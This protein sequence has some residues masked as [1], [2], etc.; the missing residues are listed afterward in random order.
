M[1]RI[2]IIGGGFGGL[3]AACRLAARGYDVQLFEK[4]DKLGGQAYTTEINGFKFDAGPSLIT[5]PTLLDDIFHQTGAR[6]LDYFE[7]VPVDPCYRFFDHR[8]QHFDYSNNL[9]FVLDQIDRWNPADKL[10]YQ[11]YL[12]TTKPLVDISQQHIFN[13]PFLHLTDML[14]IAPTLIKHRAYQSVF[15][16]VS[17]FIQDDFLRR[18]FSFHPLMQGGN[19]FD[20]STLF[21]ANQ[22]LDPEWG[23]YHPVGGVSAIVNG[24]TRLFAELGGKV[25]LNAEVVEILADRREVTGVRL[26]DG[27]IHRADAILSNAEAAF[28]YR[29][30]IHPRH[31]HINSNRRY[32]HTRYGM[33]LFVLFLGVKRRYLDSRLAHH[34]ILFCERYKALMH[35]IF[36]RKILTDDFTLFLHIPSLT[37][38]SMCPKDHESLCV[39]SPVPNLSS[40]VDWTRSAR[41]YRNR[42]LSFLEDNYLPDL[43][44]NIVAEHYLDPLH[45]QN[46]LNCT[47]GAPFSIQPLLRQSG[48]FRPH[49]R[50]EDFDNLFLVGAGTHPGGGLPG[51][52]ASAVIC[53]NLVSEII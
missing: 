33:S 47:L 1:K 42:I 38:S 34:N 4:Q 10:G 35:N 26:A 29:S 5:C 28:T 50:S 8:G 39:I 37:D 30:L 36:N 24:L 25:H 21:A 22:R 43:R 2:I 44:V 49:N 3:A 11:R 48:W 13:K 31:R 17:H 32:H 6:R 15:S 7:L 51:V 18:V 16:T 27:S 52:L 40:G 12:S 14:K 45:F 53:Q 46:T 9:N 19:P 41:P 20:T 23:A